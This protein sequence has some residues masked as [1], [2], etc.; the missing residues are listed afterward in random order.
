MR[1]DWGAILFGRADS[2]VRRTQTLGLWVAAVLTFSV[3]NAAAEYASLVMEAD[4]GRVLHSIN[5]D[6]QNYPASLTKMM[7]L[8]LVFS[9]LDR[10]TLTLD[11]PLSVSDHAVAQ[12]PSKL[13]LAPGSTIHLGEAILA[14]VTKSANDVAVV[15]AENIAGSE[16]GFA[17]RMTAT[18]QKLGMT[19]T[20][21]RNASGLPNPGQVTTAHDMAVLARALLH[22]FPHHYHYF[23][24]ASFTFY[25]ATIGNHNHLLKTYAGADGIKTGYIA[26]SGF[27]LVASAQRNGV[28]L[29]GVVMGGH[30]AQARDRHMVQLLDKGFV[31]VNGGSSVVVASRQPTVP[32]SLGSS[33]ASVKRQAAAPLAQPSRSGGEW[34]VQIGAYTSQKPAME[35]ARKAVSIVPS[36]LAQ[37]VVRVEPLHQRNG[38]TLYRARVVGIDRKNAYAACKALKRANLHCMEM[39]LPSVEVAEN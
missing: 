33:K 36:A 13:G 30:T 11:S 32:A 35:S 26:A 19:Q 16:E 29:I 6:I 4:T 27:N 34:A 31:A 17:K 21:F 37:G 20:I 24:T 15:V 38:K 23:G 12:A 7:T 9:A 3:S 22:D 18:A 5:A 1:F 14:L 8:Y 10:G 28:R 25:G 2:L 39:R